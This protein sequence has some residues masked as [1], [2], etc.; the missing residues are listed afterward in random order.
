MHQ[1]TEATVPGSLSLPLTLGYTRSLGEGEAEE[2]SELISGDP[3][4]Q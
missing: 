2:A 4:W 3:P 1:A